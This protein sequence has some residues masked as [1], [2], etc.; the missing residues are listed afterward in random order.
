MYTP[1]DE[2]MPYKMQHND[3]YSLPRK[4]S[5]HK[6]LQ[7]QSSFDHVYPQSSI[8]ILVFVRTSECLIYNST[9][10]PSRRPFMSS[11]FVTPRMDSTGRIREAGGIM[12]YSQ[13]SELWGANLSKQFSY[14]DMSRD[15]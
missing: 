6:I 10:Q 1:S 7:I 8:L 3:E 5:R 2:P 13:Y 9:T 4:Y 15:P 12:Q 14:N 11:I